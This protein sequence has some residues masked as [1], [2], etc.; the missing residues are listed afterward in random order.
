M[1]KK[2]FVLLLLSLNLSYSAAEIKTADDTYISGPDVDNFITYMV[3][4]YNLDDTDLKE[5]LYKAKYQ[6]NVIQ[7]IQKPAEKLPWYKYENLLVKDLRVKNGVKFW[8]ENAKTLE[9]AHKEFGVPPEII[10]ALIGIETSYGQNKGRFPV[11]DTLATLAFYYPPR[12]NFFRSELEHFLVYTHEEHTDP[13]NYYGSYA[14]AMGYP[15]F[16]SSS[17]R[18]FAVDFSNSGHRDLLNNIDDAIGSVGNFLNK[19]GWQ[20]DA[21]ITTKVSINK[22]KPKNYKLI[23]QHIDKLK[24]ELTVKKLTKLG[25]VVSPVKSKNQSQ[26][27][28]KNKSEVKNNFENLTASLLSFEIEKSKK[29]NVTHISKEYRLGFNNFYVITRYNISQNYALAAYVLSEK[30]K[31]EYSKVDQRAKKL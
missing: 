6:P 31:K 27:T 16:I 24:P 28:H 15:Q 5:F 14:G 23:E 29:T 30:I 9:R 21:P 7:A 17:I 2:I 26:T 1:L 10:V 20:K 3:D 4:K 13:R 8:Q 18:N 12:A 11:L 19:H 25:A 22:I